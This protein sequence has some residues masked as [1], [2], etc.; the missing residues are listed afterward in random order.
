MLC[1]L[2]EQ[3]GEPR[4]CGEGPV[5]SPEEAQGAERASSCG[6]GGYLLACE[7]AYTVGYRL[8]EEAGTPG[9]MHVSVVCVCVRG[10]WTV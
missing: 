2:V 8:G 5:F 9:T 1:V 10:T 3:F 6:V 4:R 7:E